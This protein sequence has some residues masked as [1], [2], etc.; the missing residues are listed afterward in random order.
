MG[1][2]SAVTLAAIVQG[3]QNKKLPVIVPIACYLSTTRLAKSF[4]ARCLLI[5]YV[6]VKNSSAD[7]LWPGRS[8][9]PIKADGYTEVE[10][11]LVGNLRLLDREAS[12]SSR[13]LDTLRERRGAVFDVCTCMT[14]VRAARA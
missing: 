10:D 12:A 14:L 3:K 6:G 1:A 2:F 5:V 8:R 13:V 11:A 7:S 4:L 9:R